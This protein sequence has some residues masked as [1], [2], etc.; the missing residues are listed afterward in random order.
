M[1]TFLL[2]ASIF[3][4][5]ISTFASDDLEGLRRQK[6]ESEIRLN[7]LKIQRLEKRLSTSERLEM[8]RNR[9]HGVQVRIRE[10]DQESKLSYE[11]IEKKLDS[12]EKRLEKRKRSR[13]R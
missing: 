6:Y 4:L 13:R 12:I 3:F 5:S 2:S 9:L 11:I 8:M 1:K 10:F 7:E